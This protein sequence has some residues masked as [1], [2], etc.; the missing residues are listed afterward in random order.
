MRLQY[1]VA[2]LCFYAQ[3]SFQRSLLGR[4]NKNIMIKRRIPIGNNNS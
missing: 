2:S 1:R 4:A 3:L